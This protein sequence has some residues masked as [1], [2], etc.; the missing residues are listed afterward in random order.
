MKTPLLFVGGSARSGSTLLERMLASIPG[1]FSV[2]E[3]A[4]VWERS[5]LRNDLCGCGLRFRDCTFWTAVGEAAFGGWPQV[6]AAYAARLH[7]TIDRHRNLD[8]IS[9]LRGPGQL[10]SAISAYRALTDRLYRG[11]RDVSGASVLIDAS[12]QVGYALLL[13]DMPSVELRLLHLVRRSRGVAYSWSRRVRK[14]DVGDGDGLMSVHSPWW[15]VSLWVTDNCCTTRSPG[16][17]RWP[18]WSGTKTWSRLRGLSS[19][20]LS[21]NSSCQ[22]PT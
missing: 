1:Y 20:R 11:V 12:K 9:G 2:G 4:F 17:R 13:R 22:R 5:V 7:A 10:G 21:A 15:T 3:L 8:R 18:R 16:G 6:D 14:P 19:P